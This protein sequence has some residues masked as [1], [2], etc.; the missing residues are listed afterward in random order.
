MVGVLQWR[1]M[2][3]PENP[4][5][6]LCAEGIGAEGQGRHEDA[7]ALYR[8]AWAIHTND[9]EACIAAH[10]LAREQE[11]LQESLK[12][13]RLALDHALVVAQ[14]GTAD[15]IAGFLPSLYLNLGWSHEV[16]GD[17]VTARACYLEGA[18]RVAGLPA[19][20]YTDVVRDGI[21]RGLERTVDSTTKYLL[22]CKQTVSNES[23]K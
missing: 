9:Y 22:D 21:A 7:A 2:I 16:L 6:R 3:D 19:G 5:V 14:D 8:E 20:A 11:T 4:V 12:W 18:A 15:P 13:N 1:T 17:P 23:A 10:Y